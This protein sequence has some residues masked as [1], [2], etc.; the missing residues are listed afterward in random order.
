MRALLLDIETTG[1]DPAV[2]QIIE[3]GVI[4]Y[5]V[6]ARST[7][8]QFSGLLPATKKNDA[9]H[10]NGISAAACNEAASLGLNTMALARRLFYAADIIVGHNCIDFDRKFLSPEWNEKPWVCTKTDVVWPKQIKQGDSLVNIALA[11]GIG[12]ASAHRALTDCQLIA[13]LFDR[14]D[15]LPSILTMAMRPK[16]VMVASVSF[17]DRH[18]AR[19]TGFTWDADSKHW[20]RRMAIEDVVLLP[21]PVMEVTDAI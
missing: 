19:D 18:L 16:A 5:S 2:D 17:K 14:M 7:L 15:D 9:H 12:V 21:F 3:L 1:V 10:V 20:T 6:E 4:L 8:F 13:A 11:H